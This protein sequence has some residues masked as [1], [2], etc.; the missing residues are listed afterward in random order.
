MSAIRRAVVK[1]IPL[2]AP[3][4]IPTLGIDARSFLELPATAEHRVAVE[5]AADPDPMSWL[6]S[7]LYRV[8]AR[9]PAFG[10]TFD[11]VRVR[12]E[13]ARLQV[14]EPHGGDARTHLS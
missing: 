10:D 4:T 14:V 13:E 8:P 5:G 1:P 6:A 9:Y 12:S 3:V 11:P 2:A 7:K